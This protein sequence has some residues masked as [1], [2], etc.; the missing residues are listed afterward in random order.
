MAENDDSVLELEDQDDGPSLLDQP[1]GTDWFLANTVHLAEAY[2]IEQGITLN[3]GGVLITG[4]V[5]SGRSYFKELGEFV[6]S[7]THG[8]PSEAIGQAIGDANS[9]WSEMF[10][11]AELES[12]APYRPTNY[13]HLRNAFVI[14]SNGLMSDKKG[15][16]WRGKLS[17]VDGYFFGNSTFSD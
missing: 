1:D 4:V 7:K 14:G 16:L 3:V 13:I 9:Q 8:T 11:E 17:A 5:M 2:N 12:E 15:A 6:K 10:P